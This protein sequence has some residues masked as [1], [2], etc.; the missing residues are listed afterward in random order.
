MLSRDAIKAFAVE[1][2]FGPRDPLIALATAW[3]YAESRADAQRIVKTFLREYVR[4]APRALSVD[5]C[6]LR[7]E[8]DND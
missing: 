6:R 5:A 3:T 4:F 2:T 7:R 8:L 1:S